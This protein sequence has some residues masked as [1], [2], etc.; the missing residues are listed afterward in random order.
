MKRFCAIL[1]ILNGSLFANAQQADTINISCNFVNT[2]LTDAITE[3]EVSHAVKFFFRHEWTDSLKITLSAHNMSLDDFLNITVQ[4]TSLHYYIDTPPAKVYLFPGKMDIRILPKFN[5][6][7]AN[8][9]DT[10]VS[11][12]KQISEAEEK[13]MKGRRPDMMETIVIGRS[14]VSAGSKKAT[15]NGKISDLQTGEPLLGA[16][17]FIQE[18]NIGSASDANGLLSITLNPGKYHASFQCLGMANK[19]CL[20]DV[21]SSG[22]FNIALDKEVTSIDEVIVTAEKKYN[23]AATLGM[24]Y[25]SLKAVK[26]L[27][28]LMGERDVLKVSQLLPGV[29]SVNEVSGGINVR[30]GNAD[31]NLF[32]INDIPI[33]NTSHVFGFFS[34]INP[35][36]VKDFV[37]YKGQ[38]PVEYGGRLSSI[39]KI[40]TRKGNKKKFFTQGG[41]SPVSAN[42][43][44]EVPLFKDKCSLV[45]SARSSYSD[46]ILKRLKDPALRNSSSNFYDFAG[47]VDYEL[48]NKNKLFIFSYGSK[49]NFNY[50]QEIEYE[51]ANLG[52]SLNFLHRFTPNLKSE[53]SFSNSDYTFSNADRTNESNSYKHS[54]DLDQVGLKANLYWSINEKHTITIGSNLI[55]YNLDRGTVSPLL[56]ESEVK[57]NDLGTEH[58]MESALYIDEKYNIIRWLNI[59]GGVRYSSYQGLGPKKVVQYSPNTAYDEKNIIDTIS[60]GDG[61]RFI[62]YHHPEFRFAVELN[63][64]PHSSLKF[65]YTEMSQYLFMLSNTISIAPSDQWKLVDN[66][67]KPP[68]SKQISSGYY[69]EFPALALSLSTEVY[70]KISQN[71][72]EYKDG[73]NFLSGINI[74]TEILQGKQEAYGCEFMLSKTGGRLNGWLSYAYSRSKITVNGY[75]PW[76]KINNGETYPSNYDKPH[77]LNLVGNLHANRRFIFS[78]NLSY[79]SGRPNTMPQEIYY[80]D[81]SRYVEYSK[82][83]DYRIPDYFRLDLS[84]TFEGNLKVKKPFHSSWM[85]SVYNATGRKNANSI[86]FNSVDGKILGYKYSIIGTRLY[87]ITWN[88]KLGNYANE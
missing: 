28:G 43:E 58:G 73:A 51:Y 61:D 57:I 71:I 79:S 27:P 9:N 24:E 85:F 77:V 3:I 14:N 25:I 64:G 63:T 18:L 48:N 54:Y 80:I 7:T 16:T 23:K 56:P 50:N 82:R 10:M 45:L 19:K 55:D 53:V 12:Q 60:F 21:R 87:T 2:I 86:Y 42:A 11:L 6:P 17:L 22:F 83:N 59:Y 84:L 70:Y 44:V 8:E 74:E 30:G 67:I 49:D 31:Q 47:S 88:F 38:I 40:E 36:L 32:Y 4:G 69:I 68:R 75:Y 33:L 20:L 35:T 72:V 62:N 37:I 76:Q 39:F 13:Y 78:S 52:T 15:I 34:A 81:G 26:E 66:Y 46:W 5:L 65:S 41:I 1:F 29:V